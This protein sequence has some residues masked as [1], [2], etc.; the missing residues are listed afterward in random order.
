MLQA[1][2]LD[3]GLLPHALWTANTSS[4]TGGGSKIENK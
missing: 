2:T 4:L 3:I 1:Q